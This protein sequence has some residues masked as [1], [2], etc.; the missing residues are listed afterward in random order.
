MFFS[1]DHGIRA[2]VFDLDGT[3]YVCERFAAL[4][5][6]AA[7]DYMAGVRGETRDVTRS[8]MAATRVRMAEESGLVPTLSAV[9][10][11]LG[12]TAPALHGWFEQCLK[13]EAYLKRDER[14][15]ELLRRLGTNFDLYLYTNNNR[16]LTTRIIQLLGFAGL[17]SGI[18]TIDDDWRGKPDET[19]LGEILSGIGHEPSM[20]LFVGDRYDVDLRLPEQKGCPIFLSRTVEQLLQLDGLL[21]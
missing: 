20:V 6:E 1:A 14:V 16:V 8:V 11:A 12:G 15:V 21:G 19:R 5:Q 3:L 17:F 18:F 10:S 7:V 4:I 2:L 13:P 9:C